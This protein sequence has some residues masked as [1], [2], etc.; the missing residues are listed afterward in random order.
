M[1]ELGCGTGR[2]SLPLARAG[3]DLVGID[4]SDAML[5]RAAARRRRTRSAGR[6][7]LVRGD[8]RALPFAAHAFETVV[9]PY[10]V[11]QS[12]VRERDLVATLTSVARVLAP[13]GRLVWITPAPRRTT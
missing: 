1:L 3:V 11:L 13:G 5:G 9:A 4:R 7:Q 10:G 12:I 2:V 8:I 6:L